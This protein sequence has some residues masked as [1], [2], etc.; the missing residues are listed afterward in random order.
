MTITNTL[1][2]A[3]EYWQAVEPAYKL[4]Y[5]D[6]QDVQLPWEY[7]DE[8][9][10]RNSIYPIYL[11]LPLHLV[12]FLGIDTNFVVRCVPYLA[13]LPIVLITDLYMWRVSRRTV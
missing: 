11:S 10:L 5:G 3:D 2:C 12:R 9:R 7:S 13:H 4:V 8:F 6:V 1:I